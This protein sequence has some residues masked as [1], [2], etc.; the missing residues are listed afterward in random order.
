MRR[1]KKELSET[2]EEIWR[3]KKELKAKNKKQPESTVSSTP[4]RVAA[5]FLESLDLEPTDSKMKKVRPVT[6]TDRIV[7]ESTVKVKKE[8]FRNY[9][10]K[11]AE[12]ARHSGM[13]RKQLGPSK[14]KKI[15][16]REAGRA[17]KVNAVTEFL[18]REDNSYAL[19]DKR[20]AGRYA[21]NDTLK[22]LY[23]KYKSET[24]NVKMGRSTFIANRDKKKFKLV[25]YVTRNVC[26]CPLHANIHLMM[27]ACKGLPKS[28]REL[29][30]LPDADFR[31][32]LSQVLEH[33]TPVRFSR[34][35]RVKIK[36]KG[37][38]ITKSQLV[39]KDFS[40]I[41]FIAFFATEM[42]HFRPHC[43]YIEEIYDNIKK[44]KEDLAENE[45]IVQMD[46]AENFGIRFYNEI[47]EVY[48]NNQQITI[49]PMVVYTKEQGKLCHRS[50]VGI[51]DDT[52]HTA[53]TSFSFISC[54]VT[55]IRVTNPSIET[56]H[57]ITDSPTSQ[58]RNRT[59]AHL[60]S[61]FHHYLKMKASWTWLE[62]GHGKGPCD[63]VGG[64]VKRAAD[65]CVKGNHTIRNSTDLVNELERHGVKSQLI[66]CSENWME[67]IRKKVC[68]EWDIKPVDGISNFHSMVGAGEQSV[69]RKLP[70]FR[71]CCHQ[72]GLMSPNLQNCTGDYEWR[73]V[74]GKA[75]KK[76]KGKEK[77]SS[78]PPPKKKRKVCRKIVPKVGLFVVVQDDSDNFTIGKLTKKIE[79]YF[80]ITCLEPY[81]GE[82]GAFF[83]G[84][85]TL[86]N[87]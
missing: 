58:F 86:Q 9:K 84:R 61:H 53:P 54:L 57:F 50:Y 81:P 13:T 15:T 12:I 30:K 26:L 6:E 75:P 41:Q 72:P 11:L 43:H 21:L 79:E 35:E 33:Q 4:D 60:V 7:K 62:A 1:L 56:I 83:W 82:S 59:I 8:L 51:T 2:K 3:V 5:S 66:V 55:R 71:D 29:V 40:K 39:N 19:P 32:K 46:Y 31:E 76:N 23:T 80:Q 47:T 78:K 38:Q 44:L 77:R 73:P 85:T 65:T 74:Y 10:G 52:N 49:F 25:R 16:A 45:C 69:M 67:S 20:N 14:R 64:A 63:G 28:S 17:L 22:N 37:K 48:Y 68:S 36:H 70:C 34:W 87:N 18:S 42:N 24:T 27:D